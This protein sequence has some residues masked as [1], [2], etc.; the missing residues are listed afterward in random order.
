MGRVEVGGSGLRRRVKGQGLILNF[1]K[2]MHEH[3]Q[4]KTGVV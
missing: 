2:H 1:V 3:Q 4:G